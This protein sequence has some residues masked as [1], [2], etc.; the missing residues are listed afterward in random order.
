M[1][2]RL[3]RNVFEFIERA[4]GYDIEYSIDHYKN[5]LQIIHNKR[6]A[7]KPLSNSD[8]TAISSALKQRAV[9]GANL[10]ELLHE[11]CA[12]MYEAASRILHQNAYDEQIISGLVMYKGRVAEMQTGEGKTLAALFPAYLHAL[13]IWI[14]TCMLVTVQNVTPSIT[15][16][17]RLSKWL[18]KITQTYQR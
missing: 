4:N 15:I 3:R 10:D 2:S 9:G 11:A 14:L 7:F 6:Q 13:A 18:Q 17:C 16:T 8:I 5:D 1:I 12:L